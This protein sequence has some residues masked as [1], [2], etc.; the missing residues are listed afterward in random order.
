[1][2]FTMKKI[3][4]FITLVIILIGI[5]Y[6]IG[7][8][9]GKILT[10]FINKNARGYTGIPLNVEKVTV[11]PVSAVISLHSISIQDSKNLSSADSFTIDKIIINFEW[12]PIFFRKIIVEKMTIEN[13][14]FIIK[15][16]EK[17]QFMILPAMMLA[18]LSRVLH[19]RWSKKY[20]PATFE[21]TML[22]GGSIGYVDGQNRIDFENVYISL[23]R[24]WRSPDRKRLNITF[25]V[26]GDIKNKKGSIEVA[27]D[28]SFENGTHSFLGETSIS[29][30]DLTHI[31]SF[32]ENILPVKINHGFLSVTGKPVCSE[33]RLNTI[34]HVN[35][36]GLR[37]SAL[38]NK[39]KIGGIP[40]SMIQKFLDSTKG[41]LRSDLHITGTLA[42]PAFQWN[43]F[44]TQIISQRLQQE[45]MIKIDKKASKTAKK[46][47]DILKK[48]LGKK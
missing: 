24:F 48:S 35:L 46:I 28:Y 39:P 15:R 26:N 7:Y 2:T 40:V 20:P 33:D 30:I 14:S 19:P 45:T 34:L 37:I 1:M 27:G 29:N 41:S 8:I 43:E 13:P 42:K 6:G 11:N 36:D 10:G 16:G 23:S 32:L 21:H 17:K 18:P 44:L 12:M 3:C 38:P 4:A 31:N 47:S 9:A 25:S 22:T 5:N